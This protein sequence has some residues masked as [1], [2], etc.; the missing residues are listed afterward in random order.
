VVG[1]LSSREQDYSYSAVDL[2]SR[3]PGARKAGCWQEAGFSGA[4]AMSVL[5]EIKVP[6]NTGIESQ[7]GMSWLGGPQEV[8]LLR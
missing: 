7:A 5:P 2:A 6:L 3:L 8:R 4:V 1:A